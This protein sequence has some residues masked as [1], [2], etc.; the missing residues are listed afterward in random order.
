MVNAADL[1]LESSETLLRTARDI[2]E[3]VSS[4]SS[5]FDPEAEDDLL[6]FDESGKADKRDSN[7]LLRM[8]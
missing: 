2:V 6:K 4:R 1:H 8:F 3:Q 7:L 5:V